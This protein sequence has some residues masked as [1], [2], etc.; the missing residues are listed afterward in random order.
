MKKQYV[1][2]M[3]VSMGVFTHCLEDAGEFVFSSSLL[4]YLTCAYLYFINIKYAV[5]KYAVPILV[6]D[7]VKLL[8]RVHS[9]SECQGHV[10]IELVP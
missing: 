7:D 3:R 6:V 5:V 2:F 1:S 9:A 4:S 10:T 8:I